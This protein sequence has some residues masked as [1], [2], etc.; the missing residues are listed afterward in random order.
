MYTFY[1]YIYHV[2]IQR[3]YVYMHEMIDDIYIILHIIKVNML[4]GNMLRSLS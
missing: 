1:I 3:I 2:W 4:K